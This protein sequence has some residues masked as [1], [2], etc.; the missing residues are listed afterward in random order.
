M[1][2]VDYVN[3]QSTCK[4]RYV[5]RTAYYGTY[6]IATVGGGGGGA[7]VSEYLVQIVIR[8]LRTSSAC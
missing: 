5:C 6:L 2:I 7:G 1:D 8:L 3:F 4:P